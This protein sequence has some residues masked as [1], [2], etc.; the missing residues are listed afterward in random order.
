MYIIYF[1]FKINI[2]YVF[3][4]RRMDEEYR[5]SVTQNIYHSTIYTGANELNE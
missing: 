3:E 1:N 5:L 2:W 4:Q